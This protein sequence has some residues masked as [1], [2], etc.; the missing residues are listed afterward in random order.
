MQ[1]TNQQ[2]TRSR[3]IVVGVGVGS[4]L[5]AQA[6]E[7][8]GADL[9][10]CYSTAIYRVN[11]LNSMLSMLPYGDCNKLVMETFP[12]IR[13][14]CHSDM[15]KLIGLG[16][17]D[18]RLDLPSL[19]EQAFSLGADG[20]V[21]EPFV[22]VYGA[23]IRNAL[24]R[25][26]LGYSRELAALRYCVQRGRPALGWAFSPQQAQEI[27]AAGIPYVGLMLELEPQEDVP[28]LT[29]R[30]NALTQLVRAENP[31][32]V[33]LLHGKPFENADLLREVLA[34]S[35]ADGYF[36][37]SALERATVKHAICGK[38]IFYKELL[39]H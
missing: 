37:G 27:A 7:E 17:H 29:G 14:A 12:A 11:G 26:G 31:D 16:V 39:E 18:P 5:N 19:L 3:R 21:N 22:G 15:P 32:A 1:S 8:A 28:H 2:G 36:T 35:P 34:H 23:Q 20:F 33:V 6:A 4:G 9:I 13:A 24:E 30:V 38:L 25:E 10:A